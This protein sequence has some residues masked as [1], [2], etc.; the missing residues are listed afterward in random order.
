MPFAWPCTPADQ[1]EAFAK[2]AGDGA[3]VSEIAARFG[4]SERTVERRL[5]LGNAAPE[6]L[7]A[8]RAGHM[9]LECLQAFCATPD[10]ELQLAVWEELKAQHYGPSLWQIRRLP[11]RG[12]YPGHLRHRQVHR[13]GRVRK[14]P[15]DR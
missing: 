13:R 14:S 8:Y 11:E 4:V 7:E 3:T 5:R 12:P 2:L 15:A 1:V 9:G 6:L 10:T